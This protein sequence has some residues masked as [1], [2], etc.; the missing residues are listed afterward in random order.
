MIPDVASMEKVAEFLRIHAGSWYC[1]ACISESAGVD[2]Y[3]VNQITRPPVP[4]SDYQ[5]ACDTKC[6]RCGK[7]RKCI[8]KP[9][10]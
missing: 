8:R 10:K 5:R 2:A 9:R 3:H 4:T 7:Y 1:D 6:Q